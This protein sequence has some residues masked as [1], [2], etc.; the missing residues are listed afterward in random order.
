MYISTEIILDPDTRVSENGGTF[1]TSFRFRNHKIVLKTHF[2]FH[3]H[4]CDL[5]GELISKVME[6]KIF[7]RPS[8]PL[9]E[10]VRLHTK[11][12]NNLIPNIEQRT[13][14]LF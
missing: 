12:N 14:F 5:L 7:L 6:N 8:A 2:H 3:L 4:K 10:A 1:F 9:L 13:A 11:L